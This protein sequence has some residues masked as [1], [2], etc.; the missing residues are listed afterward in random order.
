MKTATSQTTLYLL[1]IIFN[2]QL[3]NAQGCVAIRHFSS[4]VGNA[5]ENNLL[6]PGDI[7][8]GSNYRYFKSFRHF[9]GTEEEAD[10]VANETEVVNNSH[11]WDF[12][13]TYGIT[14]RLY[15]SATLPF[16]INTR[17]SLYEHGRNERNTTFSRGLA[18]VRLGVGYWVFNPTN[19]PNGNLALG[20]GIKLPTGNYNASDI[21][22]NVG[23]EG[24]PQ[25]RP[26]DQSIQPGDG[27]FGITLDFQLYKKIITD[28]YLY[29]GGFYLINP[30]ETNGTRTFRET[31]SPILENEAIM[32][33][34]DQFSSRLGLSYAISPLFSTSLGA[35]FEGVPVKDLMGGNKGFRRPGNVLSLDPGL[36]YMANNLS[37]NLNVPIALRRDRPQSVTDLE[38]Q[39]AT[40]NPRNGDA[41]F[42]DYAI[43]L[44]ITFRLP[45]KKENSTP[46]VQSPF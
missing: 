5:L 1:L 43:N 37:I 29:A 14:D 24:S 21:F 17:S 31:L 7:Q 44:G 39:M 46:D 8:I 32:A 4:C 18:D 20:L 6:G 3:I 35:R 40:G 27:G 19:N 26:V 36:A 28:F 13:I 12:F 15:A 41:A 16:V 9:R 11:A 38:T 45:N 30:R 33:V 2:F 42:A 25:V 23:P 34:P 22:Y 10:R